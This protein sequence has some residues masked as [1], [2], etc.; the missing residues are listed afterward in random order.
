MTTHLSTRITGYF[1]ALFL[2]AMGI[3]FFLWYFGLPQFGHVGASEQRLNEAVRIMEVKADIQRALVANTLR[4][5][6]GDLLVVAENKTLAKQLAER[7]P[8]I[9]QDV[10]RVFDRMQRAY[11]DRYE[12]LLIVDPSTRRIT[13]SSVNEDVGQLFQD[14]DLIQRATQPGALE[15]VEQLPATQSAPALVIARQIHAPDEYGYT[16]GK[17]VGILIAFVDLRHFISAGFF[18]EMPISGQRGNTLLF[19]PAGQLLAR[20]PSVAPGQETF[21]LNSEVAAGFEGTLKATDTSGQALVVVYRHLQLSGTQGW[22]LVHYARQIEA[23]GELKGRANTLLIAG[24]ILTLVALVLIWLFARRLTRPLQAL[25]GGARQLGL[26]DMSVR[27]PNNPGYSREFGDLSDAFNGMAESVQKAHQTL[28]AKVLERTANLRATLDAIPDLMFEM[29]LDGS[30]YDYHSPRFDLLIAPAQD[31][32]GKKITDVMQP[33][34]AEVVMAA[35]Q[36]AHARGHSSGKQIE[37]DLPQGKKWFELSI[38]RKEM[39]PSE[40]P[41][42]IVLSR[43]ITE[44]KLAED[45]LMLA[46]SVFTCAR[47]AIMITSIDGTIID[48]NEAFTHITSYGRE[49]V[50]GQNPRILSSGRQEKEF[51]ATL[52]RDL[53]EKGHWYGEVWNRRKNGEVYAV[54]QTISAVRDSLGHIS[55]YVAL[56]S[57]ITAIKEHQSQLEHI[58]HY[59]VLT[60]LPNRSLLADRLQQ[61]MSQAQRRG[62]LLA[63]AYLDLDGFKLINDRHGHE[64]GDQL[65]IA[66]A[67]RMKDSLREVDTLAR[68]GGDE[69]VAILLDLED[70]SAS[71]TLLERLLVAAALPVHMGAL[72]LQLSASLGVTF[73]PQAQEVEAD[74]L[75]RQADQAMY[76]AK[77]AGKN[78]FHVFD[79]EQDSSVRGHHESLERIR[80][81]L[82][83][84]EFVLYYQPKVNLRTGRVIGAEALI[85]WQHPDKGLLSPSVFLPVI[86]DHPLAVD[87]G[88]WVIDTALTQMDRWR[89]LG[90]DVPVSVNVGARQLQ[91]ANFV[92]RLVVLLAGH[93][94]VSPCN[95]ELEVLETS[96]L[97]DLARVSRVIEA[98][99]EIGVR[100]ALD[101][102]GTGYSS[103]TY[104]KR[105]SVAQLKID[106]SF[107]RDMLDDPD[108]LAILDGV[109]SLASAFRREVIAE[110]VETV[111]HGE[112]LLQLGCDLAQG[113]G[114]SR[115]MPAADFLGW[116]QGWQPDPS[117]CHV[118]LA[119][120]ED[121]PLLFASVEHR[122]WVKTL[123]NY[124]R[125]GI[126]KPPTL[127]HPQQ[128]FRFWMEGAGLVRPG[129]QPI[130][131][132]IDTLH[133]QLL[134]LASE[135]SALKVQGRSADVALRLDE[136]HRLSNALLEQLNGLVR[137]SITVV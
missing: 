121:L 120:R 50:L 118:P 41:R 99:R 33:A 63:V 39:L 22:T 26:G 38:A 1:G 35:L 137:Q 24:L 49:E 102:F 72:V 52:W 57:D 119:R 76:Q 62:Q 64:I 75:L 130:F 21:K 95:L 116:A 123:E 104:L 48:V 109:I 30:Y 66:L 131:S 112:M 98:C 82:T 73:Y 60:S 42:F 86:E 5:R 14:P 11:P 80:R 124:L 90:L 37:L 125:A 17:L 114:I 128:H 55:Q 93:P 54:M 103:L 97:Q 126:D 46:A 67:N 105:L 4:E 108:D 9:Q 84:H 56:F 44:R 61:S 53:I 25:A 106:Q 20:F 70:V 29:G 7:D 2:A 51:Y 31:L 34:A 6:R 91:Q 89:A 134:A 115:P 85:R 77:L 135:L 69:F 107:V 96:A 87:V 136:L 122:A 92:D 45:N 36:E 8:L 111:A 58:A 94:Q 71:E 117:W 78:R 65:L 132:S 40:S 83:E 129:V 113:F 43:D 133:Q 32:I 68:L 47:E 13:A 100:F 16:T 23:L 81:A 79:A 3:L 88:E 19:D 28:E 127:E 10:Q 110:G 59:D 15:M 74:Q 101:D 12:R 27:V 18:D